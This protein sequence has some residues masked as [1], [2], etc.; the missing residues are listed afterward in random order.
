MAVTVFLSDIHLGANYIKNPRQH[1]KIVCDFLEKEAS[2]ANHIYLLGDV[3]DYWYEYRQVVPKGYI[4][5]FGTLARI[6]DRGVKITWLTGNHDIWLFGYLRDEIGIEII[7]S[8]YVQRTIDGKNFILSHGDRI[9]D[10]TFSFRFISSIFRN[11]VCQRLYASIHPR[12]TV[13]FAHRWSNSS[14]CS[15]LIADDKE[16]ML[17]RS[18]LDDAKKLAEKH[19]ETNY[20]VMGHHHIVIDELIPDTDC[21]LMVLGDWISQFTYAEFDGVNLQLKHFQQ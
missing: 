12:W 9:S 17:R 19:P 16:S 18:V 21:R 20:V 10:G 6:A 8:P 7:D 15:H 11:K 4:R 14:R 13:P 5:F 3:L 2:R 1:E